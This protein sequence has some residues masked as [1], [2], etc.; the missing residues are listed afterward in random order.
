MKLHE[1]RSLLNSERLIRGSSIFILR[2]SITMGETISRNAFECH[3]SGDLFVQFGG[4]L[5]WIREKRLRGGRTRRYS[6]N[7]MPEILAARRGTPAENERTFR[8]ER[9]LFTVACAPLPISSIFLVRNR[10][11]IKFLPREFI[12]SP[13]F[14][15]NPY[16]SF[17]FPRTGCSTQSEVE[18]CL[19]RRDEYFK[20][21]ISFDYN[22]EFQWY[23]SEFTFV[24][25]NNENRNNRENKYNLFSFNLLR[26]LK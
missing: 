21:E 24:K 4:P 20:R 11:P 2:S 1:I 14:P 15:R 3:E 22:D 10:L 6:E 7:G 5:G 23:P 9:A 18:T 25:F 8:K 13:T 17:L 19:S 12:A 26:Q 16:I